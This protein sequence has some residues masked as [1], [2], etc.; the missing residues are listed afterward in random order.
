VAEGL[1]RGAVVTA[2]TP[3]EYG[4]PR[5]ALIVQTDLLNPTHASCVVCPFTTE[6]IEAPEFRLDF[7]PTA[8][9]GLRIA[10]Q[11]MIDKVTTVPRRK[12][13]AVIGRLS[14]S[15]LTR[16]NEALAVVLGLADRAQARREAQ[17][18]RRLR[19]S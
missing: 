12:I 19:Q 18:A 17:R 1:K 15:D 10:S 9:N 14:R 6:R 13:G 7:Q 3:R 4:K 8:E 11:L 2:V 16:V 5:P